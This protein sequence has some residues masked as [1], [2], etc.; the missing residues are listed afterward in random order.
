[1]ASV[2][3]GLRAE[4]SDEVAM[5]EQVCQA[6]DIPFSAIKVRVGAGNLQ[7]KAREARYNA[8]T[9][10]VQQRGLGALAT[11][12]HADDQAETLLMRLA[13]GSGLSGLAGVR[14]ASLLSD[15]ETPL[16]RPLLDWRK[17]ELETLVAQSGIAPALDPSNR[18]RAFDRVRVR[19]HL[20]EHDWLDVE[21][22]ATSAEHLAD[23]WR[24][25]EWYAQID[26]E[27]MVHREEGP[28]FRYY[29]NVPRVVAIETV[30][31]IIAELGGVAT[32]SEAGRA[33]DRLW[34]EENASLAGV[35]IVP[36]TEQIQRTGVTMRVWRFTPEPPRTTN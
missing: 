30:C 3:H 34:R 32:R 23:A 28:A 16:V 35:L 9:E 21:A 19:Q 15:G 27:E 13:R 12:H 17:D 6:R 5:V 24:A 31:R 25:I 7:A 8:L 11:A 29:A 26:W 22:L 2:D 1:M 10:W 14:A 4:A 18:D 33:Y 20:A 36:G